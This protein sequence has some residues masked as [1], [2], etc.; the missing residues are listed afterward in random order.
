MKQLIILIFAVIFTFNVGAQEKRI[1]TAED[2]W[3]IKRIG[4]Y[5]ISPD[6]QQLIF[7]LTTYDIKENKPKSNLY[8]CHIASKA[9]KQF[10]FGGT[11]NNPIW[12]PD[13]KHIAF[14]SRRNGGSAQL[15]IIPTNGG[16]AKQI[17]HLPIGV[18]T[19]KWFPN[20]QKIAFVAQVTHDFDGN[21]DKLDKKLKDKKES[22][23]SAIVTED[24]LYKYWDKW[25]TDSLYPRIFAIDINNND[26]IID[27]MPGS[28][29]F[30]G[31][32]G[33]SEY[34]I[35]PDG[36]LIA[37][38]ANSTNPPYDKLNYDIFL[39]RTN[40]S[41]QIVNITED[42]PAS[43]NN[44]VF[45]NDGKFIVYGK[46]VIDHFY[47]DKVRLVL[48]DT[49]KSEH[50]NLTEDID[51]SFEQWVVDETNKTIYAHAEVAGEKSIFSFDI[52]NRKITELFKGGTN[53]GVRLIAGNRLLFTHRHLD[54]PT[55]IY[56]IQKNGKDPQSLTQINNE[57][58]SQFKFGNVDDVRYKGAED[59]DIQLYIIYPPGF[60]KNKKYPMVVMI[61]G[62]PHGV[63][64]NDFHF[65][66]NAHLFAA[67]GYV[68]VMPNFHGSTSFGQ[69]FA[70]SIHGTHP[71]KPYIDVMKAVDFMIAKGFIDEK[72]IAAAGGSYGGYLVSWIAGKTDRFATLV[73]HAG[74]FDLMQ[75]FGSDITSSRE[76]AYGGSPWHNK[77]TMQKWNPAMYAE[78]FKTPMLVM[79]GEKDYRVPINHALTVYGI[80]KGMGLDARLVY[81][82]DENHWIL[83]PQN[84]IYWYKELH[85]WFERY[86]KN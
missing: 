37:F 5:D 76:I 71:E 68:V 77:E 53:N 54:R 85:N 8:I 28:A 82:P 84:S 65:R 52:K 21:F 57:F 17:T 66:W 23:V 73:N 19:P 10:T 31:L 79:H 47:A 64:G 42:N 2:L 25:L 13:G 43:D 36:G 1:F 41:G 27:L 63:F 44:P 58:M 32:M 26:S 59:A 18:S 16:E 50:I 24:R 67:P 74:V 38:S 14:V 29:R 45:S 12:S 55:E 56:T 86:L 30:L 49:Q 4:A 75:Q 72:R 39:L 83:S 33:S 20:S 70:Y 69:D 78:N 80:Y 11:D 40:G 48:F 46:Q 7:V 60:D 6:G 9:I 51:L 62:G 3:E 81:Y 35:S 15:F 34:N 22:K 61:H